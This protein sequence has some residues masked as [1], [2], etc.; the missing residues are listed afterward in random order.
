AAGEQIHGREVL[1]DANG[2]VRAE[3]RN[4]ARQPNSFGAH[5]GGAE[6]DGRGRHGIVGAMMFAHAEY[7][8]AYFVR[9]LD[10][11]DEIAQPP[12]RADVGRRVGKAVYANV[13]SQKLRARH[14][15][16]RDRCLFGKRQTGFGAERVR[17]RGGEHVENSHWITARSR[18]LVRWYSGEHRHTW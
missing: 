5:G 9:E 15:R 8:Q 1:K 13:H 4:G 12:L 17:G 2:V 18:G 6:H 10:L 14:T 3:D 16:W 11:F 7:I